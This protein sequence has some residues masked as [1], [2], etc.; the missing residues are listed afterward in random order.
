MKIIEA[1]KR[2]NAAYQR[3]PEYESVTA[4]KHESI[5][6]EQIESDDR[7]QPSLLTHP[8]LYLHSPFMFDPYHP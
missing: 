3:R 1:E 6:Q 5:G 2:S 4:S 8:S 7:Q